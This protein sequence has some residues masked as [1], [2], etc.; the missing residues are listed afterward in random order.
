M[1]ACGP[2]SGGPAG[3][4]PGDVGGVE[5]E[6][7]ADLVGDRAERLGVDDARVGRGAGDDQLRA[8]LER[9]VADLVDSRSARRSASTP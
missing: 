8:V 2:G 6:Q 4:E 3:D 7:R 5:H 9:Q 1:S